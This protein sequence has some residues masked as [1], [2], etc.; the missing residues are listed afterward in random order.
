M[1][2]SGERR[3]AEQLGEWVLGD[4]AV[5]AES[6]RWALQKIGLADL[7]ASSEE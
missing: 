3:F 7:V 2:N 5:L 6:A 4:D 1:G